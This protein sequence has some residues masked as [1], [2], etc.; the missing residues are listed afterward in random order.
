MRRRTLFSALRSHW[1]IVAGLVGVAAL[2]VAVDPRQVAGA[3]EGANPV[4]LAAMLPVVLLLYFFHSVAWWIALRGVGVDV[5]LRQAVRVTFISQAFDVVPGGDLWRVP[6]L[7]PT[8]SGRLDVGMVAAAVIFDDLAYFLVLSLTMVPAAIEYPIVRAPFAIALAP[9]IA[10][11]TVLLWPRLYDPLVAW[12]TRMA[13][14][15]RFAPQLALLGPS[16]RRLVKPSVAVPILMADAVCSA[17]AISLYGL[18]VVAVHA[19]GVGVPQVAFIY[20]SGQVL[21]GLTVLPG[22][23]GVYEGMMTG[24]LAVQGVAVATAAA[25]ALLYRSVNDLLMALIGAVVAFFSSARG[26][27]QPG[28]MRGAELR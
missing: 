18:A 14:F 11:F 17:L 20:A 6:I 5:S 4:A 24:L 26:A 9:Q 10:I 7:R 23:L 1:I 22:A 28:A 2:I 19:G 13:L 21:S 27:R 12:V 3:L 8:K 15:R 16:V 25:A